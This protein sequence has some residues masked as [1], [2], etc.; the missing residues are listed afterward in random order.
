M[1]ICLL[2]FA[3]LPWHLCAEF[4]SIP[5]TCCCVMRA[6]RIRPAWLSV[7]GGGGGKARF[8]VPANGGGLSAVE[9]ALAWCRTQGE[10]WGGCSVRAGQQSHG[11]LGPPNPPPSL[12][13]HLWELT[14]PQPC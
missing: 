12:Q 7:F 2:F 8:S 9:M 4:S 14:I 5:L 10:T 6:F 1:A 13:P 11:H 3:V